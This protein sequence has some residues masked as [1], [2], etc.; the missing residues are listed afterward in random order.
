M[1]AKLKILIRKGAQ[2]RVNLMV[3]GLQLDRNSFS[4]FLPLLVLIFSGSGVIWDAVVRFRPEAIINF[5]KQHATGSLFVNDAHECDTDVKIRICKHVC[6]Y[7][8]ETVYYKCALSCM[9]VLLMYICY[10]QCEGERWFITSR[11]LRKL[12]ATDRLRL[13]IPIY[14]RNH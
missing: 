9:C 2:V 6:I 8:S 11:H 4:W 3:N 13:F 14:S 12:S 7:V 1:E 5:Q 10:F